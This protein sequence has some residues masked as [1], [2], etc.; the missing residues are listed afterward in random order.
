MIHYYFDK[1]L[2][3]LRLGYLAIVLNGPGK[4]KIG[5]TRRKKNKVQLEKKNVSITYKKMGLN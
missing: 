3:S 1:I 2:V 4:K 5:P